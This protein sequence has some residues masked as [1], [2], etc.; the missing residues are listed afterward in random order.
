MAYAGNLADEHATRRH[1]CGV[2]AIAT[3]PIAQLIIVDWVAMSIAHP[4]KVMVWDRPTRRLLLLK[5]CD[6]LCRFGRTLTRIGKSSTLLVVCVRIVTRHAANSRFQTWVHR[7]R[8]S[9]VA[10]ITTI[11]IAPVVVIAL[12][13]MP[14]ALPP[15]DADACDIGWAAFVCT[16]GVEAFGMT[17]PRLTTRILGVFARGVA[18]VPAVPTVELVIVDAVT[19]PVTGEEERGRSLIG[20]HLVL[21]PDC[22]R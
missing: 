21:M 11:P 8:A 6:L 9:A 22:R 10:A 5:R 13:A 3:V 16:D 4:L 12:V 2:A 7:I 18:A 15:R 20:A 17:N 14:I 19:M 1:A